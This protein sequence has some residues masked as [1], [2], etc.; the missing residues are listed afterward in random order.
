MQ[1]PLMQQ[2]HNTSTC[3]QNEI[4]IEM[5]ILQL[6]VG[7]LVDTHGK[8]ASNVTPMMIIY[9]FH[10]SKICSITMFIVNSRHI[11]WN[12]NAT[13]TLCQSTLSNLWHSNSYDF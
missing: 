1:Y 10:E 7:S 6:P 8:H 11:S 12:L 2:V 5:P 4:F 13:F 3:V 9:L